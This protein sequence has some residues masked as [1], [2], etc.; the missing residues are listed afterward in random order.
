[1]S[2]IFR[3]L[4]LCC[5]VVV[6]SSTLFAQKLAPLTV[7]KIMRD[8]KWMGVAPTNPF[9][10]EDGSKVYFSWNPDKATSDSLY[11]YDV[12][13]K[14]TRKVPPKSVV[15]CQANLA[16]RIIG[17]LPKNYIPEMVIYFGWIL[18]QIK[19]AN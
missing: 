8:P 5:A 2:Q 4:S 14:Q 19:R 9:W 11:V 18:K 10:S 15:R 7:E 17:R 6:S 12:V 13:S 1:M 3:A 16:E